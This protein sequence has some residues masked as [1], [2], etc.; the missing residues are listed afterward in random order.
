[1]KRIL[2]LFS[3]LFMNLT[4]NAE[5]NPAYI[6][7]LDSLSVKIFDLSAKGN[8][9]IQQSRKTPYG[10]VNILIVGGARPAANYTFAS[11]TELNQSDLTEKIG[12]P[13]DRLMIGLVPAK[14][15]SLNFHTN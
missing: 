11:V 4:I 6:I 3:F 9:N 7:R 10:R 14:G 12:Q 13:G 15:N 8:L 1:M 5:T 2:I